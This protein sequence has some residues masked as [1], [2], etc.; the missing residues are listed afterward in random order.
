MNDE[1]DEFF[2]SS[3]GVFKRLNAQELAITDENWTHGVHNVCAYCPQKEKALAVWT[4]E[5]MATPS[6]QSTY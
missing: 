5:L 2:V 3:K 6:V 4:A 1:V